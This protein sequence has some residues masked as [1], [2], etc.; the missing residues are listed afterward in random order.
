MTEFNFERIKKNVQNM[1]DKPIK[2]LPQNIHKSSRPAALCRNNGTDKDIIWLYQPNYGY[3]GCMISHKFLLIDKV[4]KWVESN[5]SI[6]D[7]K[8]IDGQHYR[9]YIFQ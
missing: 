2:V 8:I 4:K 6:S 1:F 3:I 5:K 9:M 7:A